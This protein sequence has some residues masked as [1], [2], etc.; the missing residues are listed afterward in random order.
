MGSDQL[1]IVYI[2][3]NGRSGSTVLDLLLGAHAACW[4]LG[5]FYVLPW[6][7]RT[8][9]KPCGCGV[10]V[11]QCPFWGSIVQ[12]QQEVLRHGSIDRFRDSYNGGRP[13]RW[14]EYRFLSSASARHR[15]RRRQSLEKYGQDNLKVL[16]R[17]LEKARA[18]KG[19]QVQ[20][21][22]DASK[23]VYRLLW[24]KESGMFDVRVVH[25]VKDPRA[26]VYSMCRG[27]SGLSRASMFAKAVL[28]W[29][30]ENHLFNSVLRAHFKPEEC[31]RLRYNELATDPRNTLKQVS[32]WL[33]L[34]SDD[35]LAVKFRDE[36]H[37]IAGN[38]SRFEATG[39]RLDEKWRFELG[40]GTRHFVRLVSAPL[41]ARYGFP[42]Q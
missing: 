31:L 15:E 37:G 22:V 39:V 32:D 17:V 26:Y 4:T 30:I 12:E 33:N 36:N 25:L 40:R 8:H 28:R 20:W 16:G 19:E 14:G 38:P 6:E 10:S 1:K 11:E 29:N 34:P 9:T 3:S 24:L 2:A 23:S 7:L 13:V 18:V 21:L 5:E 35:E 42:W 27:M 41:A